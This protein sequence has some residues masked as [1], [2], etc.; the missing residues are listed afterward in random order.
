M[1]QSRKDFIIRA[2]NSA[3][4]KWKKE[5]EKEFPNLFNQGLEVNRWYKK[6]DGGLWF[7]TE[8]EFGRS[9]GYGFDADGDWAGLEKEYNYGLDLV[10]ATIAEIE[11][12]L[13]QECNIRGLK[14]SN[15][16]CV[17]DGKIWDNNVGGEFK[18]DFSSNYLIIGASIAFEKGKWATVIKETITKEEAEKELGKTIIN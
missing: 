7:L 6:R 11:N 13:I 1:K 15:H 4:C 17:R 10:L 2:H 18:Y 8:V 3:C 9:Y 16:R 12:E 14:P 5:I